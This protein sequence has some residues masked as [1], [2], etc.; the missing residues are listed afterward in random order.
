MS[1]QF[2]LTLEGVDVGFAKSA[3]GG[4]ATTEV[5]SEIAGAGFFLK[6]HIGSPKYEGIT[7]QIGLSMNKLVYGWVTD[8]WNGLPDQIRTRSA[9]NCDSAR[10]TLLGCRLHRRGP[11]GYRQYRP[12]FCHAAL[13]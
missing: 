1:D 7:I 4:E 11:R 9:A 8:F 12:A 3:V 2:M 13:T 6:K 10:G 5:I